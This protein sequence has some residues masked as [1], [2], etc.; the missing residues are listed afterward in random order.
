M[1]SYDSILAELKSLSPELIASG[2]KVTVPRTLGIRT[3]EQ[4]LASPYFGGL[5]ENLLFMDLCKNA[6]FSD[7][8]VEIHHF[9][10]HKKREVDI[11]LEEPG[12]MITGI[13]IKAAKSFSKSDFSGLASL[14]NYAGSKFKQGFLLY[15]GDKILPVK[16]DNHSF[17][18]VPFASL[19]T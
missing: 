5:L 10:D 2:V 8:E 1:H 3:Q 14:A 13:E 18:A 19:Y 15:S 6:V 11:I 4:L 7:H 12:G 17:T 16:I 9:R